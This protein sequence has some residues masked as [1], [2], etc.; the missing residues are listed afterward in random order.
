M[1]WVYVRL[2]RGELAPFGDR[3]PIKAFV[4]LRRKNL[5]SAKLEPVT[6]SQMLKELVL[7]NF[8]DQV[9]PVQILDRLLSITEAAQ[10]C[11]LQFD[12]IGDA[13]KLLVD[14]FG[15]AARTSGR[16]R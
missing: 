1:R 16:S 3:A 15:S 12:T 4:R 2:G 6:K 7:Q 9:P 11:Q 10:C 14:K 13:A 8:A 5:G